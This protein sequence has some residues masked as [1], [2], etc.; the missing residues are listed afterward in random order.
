[1]T[2]TSTLLVA[3]AVLAVGTYAC[4]VAGPLLRARVTLPEQVERLTGRA[5]VVLLAAVAATST[6]IVDHGFAGP[7]RLVGVVVGG[8]LAWRRAPFAA[9][10][11]AAAGTTAALR[12]CGVT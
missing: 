10:V 2:G 7:A 12:A 4:R 8:L 3:I 5:T 6:L 9:V 1:M 11:L